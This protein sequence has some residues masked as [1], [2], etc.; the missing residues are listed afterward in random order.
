MG[1]IVQLNVSDGGVPK[2]S[3]PEVRVEEQGLAGDR[4]ATPIVHGGSDRA[5]VLFGR[6][7]IDRLRAEGHSIEAGSAGENV[8]VSGLDWAKV[9]PGVRLGL[10]E[11][12]VLEITDFAAPCKKNAQWFEGGDFRQLDQREHPG[13]SRVCARVLRTGTL[14]PGDP[15]AA[16][17]AAG[18]PCHSASAA[19]RRG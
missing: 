5:V 18:Q 17:N 2:R 8:T 4:Q 16:A 15:V 10:G 14:R 3:V 7:V 12:V 6:E 11:E 13:Q 19:V 9:V 1:Q